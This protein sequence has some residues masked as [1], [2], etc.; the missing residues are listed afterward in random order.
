VNG[1]YSRGHKPIQHSE[2]VKSERAQQRYWARSFVAWQYFSRALP[3]EAHKALA[4]LEAHGWV[5]GGLITQNVDGLHQAAGH[6]NCLDLHGRIDAVECLGCGATT[7][8]ADLQARRHRCTDG[9]MRAP[10]RP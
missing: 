7:T 6:A 2:F 4:A 8:R 1:S 3:N 10:P 5:D 9:S